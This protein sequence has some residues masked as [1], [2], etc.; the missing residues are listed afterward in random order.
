MVVM[1]IQLVFLDHPET[2]ITRETLLNRPIIRVV[3]A[4][5]NNVGPCEDIQTGSFK[6]IAD[7]NEILMTQVQ[8]LGLF[9]LFLTCIRLMNLDA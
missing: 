3:R 1:V 8:N 6:R 9:L 2:S 5:D 7:V 4:V